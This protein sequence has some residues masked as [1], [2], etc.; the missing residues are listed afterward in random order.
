MK[1]N[2]LWV[3]L[4]AALFSPQLLAQNFVISDIRV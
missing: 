2:S 1:R 3:L 4:W